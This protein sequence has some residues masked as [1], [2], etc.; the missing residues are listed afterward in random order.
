[1]TGVAAFAKNAGGVEITHT[2]ANVRDR[3]LCDEFF[4][5]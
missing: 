3:L 1:M 4:Q 5:M 2:L